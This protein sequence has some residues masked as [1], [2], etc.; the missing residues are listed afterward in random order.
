MKNIGERIKESWSLPS[1]I[2]PLRSAREESLVTFESRYGVG[3]PKDM[4]DYFFQV[5][6]IDQDREGFSFWRLGDVKPVVEAAKAHD[7]NWL[8]QLPEAESFFI[9]ADYLSWCW[10]YAIRLSKDTIDK[11]EVMLL[12][13]RNPIK[14]ADS[15]SEFMELYFEDNAKLYPP[16]EHLHV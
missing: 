5:D 16:K 2:F 1:L 7:L 8:K 10:G 9:F 6:G 14:I 12:C 15:F 3:F 4:R 13:C 11:N